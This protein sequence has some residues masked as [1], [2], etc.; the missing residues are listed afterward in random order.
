MISDNQSTRKSKQ[1]TNLQSDNK[2]YIDGFIYNGST[3]KGQ[4]KCFSSW[5]LLG[6]SRLLNKCVTNQFRITLAR[7][8]ISLSFVSII[9]LTTR[10]AAV[11]KAIVSAVH[12]VT[13]SLVHKITL[14]VMRI[15]PTRS[16]T[17]L[18]CMRPL[19]L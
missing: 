9:K 19:F 11:H 16:T 6:L 17:S 12:K 3:Y 1:E 7:R 2:S 18:W 15:E 10:M 13:L 14:L 4:A 5:S 8:Q